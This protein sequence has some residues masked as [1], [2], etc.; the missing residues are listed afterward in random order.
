M[1]IGGLL[2]LLA[3][4]FWLVLI[5]YAPKAPASVLEAPTNLRASWQQSDS[6]YVDWDDVSAHHQT[7][8]YDV[9]LWS[10]NTQFSFSGLSESEI[11]TQNKVQLDLTQTYELSVKVR[12]LKGQ[13]SPWA[14]LV[15][16][17]KIVSYKMPQGSYLLTIAQN[18]RQR[19]KG[20]SHKPS[21][22]PD[23][24]LLFIFDQLGDYGIWM[25]DMNFAIDI[26]WLDANF[27]I[28]GLAENVQPSS[29]PEV[30][31]APR[32]SLYVIE[33]AAGQ[34][35]INALLVGQ[36]LNLPEFLTKTS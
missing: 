17:P 22:A 21:L 11:S 1:K 12:D 28:V 23:A 24:G 5:N 16:Y 4:L 25:K 6:I 33:L 14:T 7:Y 20:L 29:Y 10:K 27:K 9:Q 3:G 15:L 8:F 36:K 35:T 31:K 18:E 26:I 2:V 19:Q 13:G 32:P 34:I 30:Y